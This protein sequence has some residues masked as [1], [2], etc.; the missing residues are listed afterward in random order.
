[1][2]GTSLLSVLERSKKK[3][4]DKGR[5]LSDVSQSRCLGPPEAGR[6]KNGS[7]F[8]ALKRSMAQPIPW[9]STSGF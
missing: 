2:H 7:F 5:D 9:F 3:K 1:M 4:K 8:R 6:G